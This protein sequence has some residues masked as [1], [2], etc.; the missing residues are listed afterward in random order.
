MPA[1]KR[2]EAIRGPRKQTSVVYYYLGMS[3]GSTLREVVIPRTRHFLK[4][5]PNT[6]MLAFTC[7]RAWIYAIFFTPILVMGYSRSDFESLNEISRI[8]LIATLLICGLFFER[9]INRM[10]K[11][12]LSV[13]PG[14]LMSLGTFMVAL[15][16]YGV[17][18]L[19]GLFA[20]GSVLT[21]A[22]SGLCI[23][24]LGKAYSKLSAPQAAAEA[25]LAFGL[26]SLAIVVVPLFPPWAGIS[27]ACALPLVSCAFLIRQPKEADTASDTMLDAL[28]TGSPAFDGPKLDG[29]ASRRVL[30]KTAVAGIVFS[31][32]LGMIRSSYN[33]A[34]YAAISALPSAVIC[35]SA[36]LGGVIVLVV[37]L[38]SA[39]LD[40]AFSY[41]P[42]LWL[43]AVGCFLLGFL[44]TSS[45]VPYFFART[46]YVCFIILTWVMLSDLACKGSISY[47]V[48]F[49]IGQACISI[50]SQLG[51][52]GASL[53]IQSGYLVEGNLPALT[54]ILVV[55]LIS[56]YTFVLTER[57]IAKIMTPQQDKRSEGDSRQPAESVSNSATHGDEEGER[58]RLFRI[59]KE[60]GLGDRAA[61]VMVLYAHGDTRKRVGQ[62]LF[63]S[64]G[65]VN[66]HLR[67]IYAALGVHSKQELIDLLDEE[68]S[69]H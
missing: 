9:G 66:T 10:S 4:V 8:A 34:N 21:G 17:R 55:L 46:G 47:C 54:G 15:S 42:V 40:L 2:D 49:A 23:L 1:R 22:G 5:A 14:I 12:A 68:S 56:V 59:A 29:K 57:D 33:F 52:S 7:Y 30:A 28:E 62:E 20:C 16:S 61:E 48:V 41:K 26:A 64:E 36:F 25:A 18:S 38:V 11:N 19:E 43:V 13:I 69:A 35:L 3:M 45:V 44:D 63:I 53:L 37:L 50:G 58:D 27:I 67:T 65:T 51:Y 31:A 6:R 60:H 24:L 39:R 32:V